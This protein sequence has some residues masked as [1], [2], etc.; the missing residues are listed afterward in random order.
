MR[1]SNGERCSSVVWA[2]FVAL[3]LLST[4]CG[5]NSSQT[6]TSTEFGTE[7]EIPLAG[8]SAVHDV[9]L[10]SGG[11]IWITWSDSA[12]HFAQ[13]L[14]LA[15]ESQG[16]PARIGPPCPGGV[17]IAVDDAVWT[18][19]VVP[20]EPNAARPGHVMVWHSPDGVRWQP[21][22]LAGAGPTSHGVSLGVSRAHVALAW[23]NRDTD[24]SRGWL[25]EVDRDDVENRRE[26]LDVRTTRLTRPG[27]RGGAPHL[28]RTTQGWWVAAGESVIDRSGTPVTSVR[29]LEAQEAE[30]EMAGL[31]VSDPT[32]A[33][34]QSTAPTAVLYRDENP[35]G[36]RVALFLERLERGAPVGEPIRIGRADI[37]EPAAF[38]RCEGERWVVVLHRYGRDEGVVAVHHLDPSFE[39]LEPEHQLYEAGTSFRHVSATCIGDSVLLAAASEAPGSPLRVVRVGSATR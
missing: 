29:L 25:A 7:Y 10:A 36:S 34:E 9:A 5:P 28:V 3:V 24:A 37:D 2:L 33:F 1:S 15:G 21:T 6:A 18:A 32:P 22:R 19:C 27:L 26:K 4:G 30:H 31:L 20:G 23:L 12:G 14:N 39:R 8:Q 11:R 35:A 17:A 13:R 38:L 16:S